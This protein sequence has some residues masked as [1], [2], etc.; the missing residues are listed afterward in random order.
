M[1]QPEIISRG[2][3]PEELTALRDLLWMDHSE[4]HHGAAECSKCRKES[5]L[6]M[7]V[8]EPELYIAVSEAVALL[9]DLAN[10]MNREHP[11]EMVKLSLDYQYAT[12]EE[13]RAAWP[14]G[15]H[16]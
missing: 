15:E 11:D 16:Q 14:K 4:R 6:R 2:K 10:E 13:V 1:N 3:L 12:A 9:H 8:Q 7:V 5:E